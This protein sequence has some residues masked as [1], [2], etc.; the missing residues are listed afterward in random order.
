M[1]EIFHKDTKSFNY[2]RNVFV[3]REIFH[4]YIMKEYYGIMRVNFDFFKHFRSARPLHPLQ[5]RREQ[6]GEAF[7]EFALERA[8]FPSFLTYYSTIL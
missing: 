8:P 5:Q 4:L 7:I 6:A 1:I 2:K 3:F